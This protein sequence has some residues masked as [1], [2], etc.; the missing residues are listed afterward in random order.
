[1]SVVEEGY[2]LPFFAFPEPAAFKNNRSALEHAEFV[3][4]VLEVLCQSGRVIR[5]AVPLYVINPLPVSV[6]ANGKK[7]LILDLRYVNRHLQKKDIKNEDWKVAISYFEVWANMFTFD[8]KSGYHHIEVAIDHQSYLGFS[9]VDPIFKRTQFYRFTVMPFWLSSAP[10]IF[11]K[12]LKPLVKHWRLN[13]VRIALFLDDCWGIASSRDECASLSKTVKNDLLSAGFVSN[14]DK[15]VWEPCQSIL[16]LGILWHSDSGAVEISERRVG[17]IVSTVCYIID[18]EF[19]ISATC[20]ASFTGQII[21][22]G[23]VV[24]SVSSIMTRHCSMSSACAPYWDAF[25]G[26]DQ[27]TKD[28][29]IFW[30]ENIDFVKSRFCSLDR[31]RHVFGFSDASASGCCA[32]ISLERQHVCYK[33][34]D[35]SE[36]SKSST[37]RELAAIDFCN[38][39][40]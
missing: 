31:K 40:V 34:W 4:S 39:V 17:K 20:L 37:W 15:S 16:W 8:L 33:L 21:S 18:C 14:D 10:H 3:E 13:G 38:R 9:W 2:K 32:D 30:K 1:M 11:T 24:G 29:I 36:A 5:C 35:S 28:E 6:Q 25:L 7:R 23:P 12:V 26:L 19:V 22:T 27:Y